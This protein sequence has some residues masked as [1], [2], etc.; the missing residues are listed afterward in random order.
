MIAGYRW[1]RKEIYKMQ[2]TMFLFI[3][4]AYNLT[5]GEYGIPRVQHP[6]TQQAL[7]S[8]GPSYTFEQLE[9]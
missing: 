7:L 1:T 9:N 3:V 2:F 4:L 8:D 5:D 6:R